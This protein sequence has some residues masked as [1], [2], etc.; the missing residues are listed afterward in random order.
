MT[1][2]S[3]HRSLFSRG[4]C[5]DAMRKFTASGSGGLGNFCQQILLGLQTRNLKESSC[6]KLQIASASKVSGRKKESHQETS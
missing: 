4:N 5:D 3:S 1:R 2:R 6:Y